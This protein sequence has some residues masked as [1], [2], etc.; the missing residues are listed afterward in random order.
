[1]NFGSFFF[2]IFYLFSFLC[3]VLRFLSKSQPQTTQVE[4]N[5][6][7]P[8]LVRRHCHGAT[9]RFRGKSW[10]TWVMQK[11]SLYVLQKQVVRNAQIN[12]KIMQKVVAVAEWA[13]HFLHAFFI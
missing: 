7:L 3:I 13:A 8:G 2:E 4:S 5:P 1:M 10:E 12:D 11:K 9:A 6:V